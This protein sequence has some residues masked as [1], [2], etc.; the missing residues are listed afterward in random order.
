M[1]EEEFCVYESKPA[2]YFYTRLY[3]YVD[4]IH[5]TNQTYIKLPACI[6]NERLKILNN[7][8]NYILGTRYGFKVK[9]VFLRRT[10]FTTVSAHVF[11]AP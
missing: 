1:Q 4:E 6:L 8:S 3:E 7:G 11:M 10:F 2:R 9:D 5:L